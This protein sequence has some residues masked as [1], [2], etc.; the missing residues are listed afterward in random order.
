MSLLRIKLTLNKGRQG[1]AIEKLVDIAKEAERFLEYFSKDMQLNR[2]DWIAENFKNGSVAFDVLYAGEA[3]DAVVLNSTKALKQI[4][5]PR[6]DVD[7]LS[8]GISKETFLQFAK[9][10]S[11]VEVD[12][13]VGVGLYNGSNRPKTFMLT[14]QRYIQIEKQVLQRVEQYGGFQGTITALFKGAQSTLWITEKLSNKRVVCTYPPAYYK[15]IVKLLEDRDCLVN[16]EGW[17][18]IVNGEIEKLSIK[19]LEPLETYRDGDIEKLFGSDPDFTGE[20][21]NE[22][23]LEVIRGE[24]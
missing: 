3:P 9:I 12:D 11:P 18:T 24:A 10:A 7:D 2:S 14:K 15:K 13:A 20:L 16:V 1:I 22:Q 8:Y 5:N 19:I 17:M 6:T 23:F 21:S 4:A